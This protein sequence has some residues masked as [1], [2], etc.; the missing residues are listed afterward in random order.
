MMIRWTMFLIATALVG[1]ASPPAG[2]ETSG[3]GAA[4]APAGGDASASSKQITPNQA[5]AFAQP[6]ADALA[7][8]VKSEIVK[9]TDNAAGGNVVTAVNAASVMGAGAEAI[10]KVSETDPVVASL[11]LELGRV[12]ET[13]PIDTERAD[14]LREQLASALQ[15]ARDSLS[16]VAGFG[17]LTTV[18]SI[19]GNTT[20]QAGHTERP[21]TDAEAQAAG[22]AY[23][24]LVQEAAGIV[25]KSRQ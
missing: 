8:A 14:A 6:T 19:I 2:L 15:A 16:S 25:E 5:I 9:P 1:C 22:I 21:P 3:G 7:T 12:I 23:T 17:S 18:V 4:V 20:S 10:A 24:E 13:E 11:V